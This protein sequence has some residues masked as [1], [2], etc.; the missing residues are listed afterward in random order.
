L[1]RLAKKEYQDSRDRNAV[2]GVFGSSKTAYGLAL[3]M[4]HL[5]E[6]ASYVIDVALLL[7]NHT[8]SL[9]AAFPLFYFLAAVAALLGLRSRA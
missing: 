4:V 6:T 5:Q 1:S 9:R 8:K 3:I 7:L 2:E